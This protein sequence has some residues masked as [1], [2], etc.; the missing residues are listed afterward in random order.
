MT[1]KDDYIVKRYL[2]KIK[3]K[4]IAKYIQCDPSLISKYEHGKANMDKQKIIK[5]KEYI[6]QKIRS[7]KDE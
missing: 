1:T 7:C 2:N 6:D 5:Y 3:I 4:E